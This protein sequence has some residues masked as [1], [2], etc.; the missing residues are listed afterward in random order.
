MPR[1]SFLSASQGASTSSMEVEELL[2]LLKS[3]LV[4]TL[5]V[6]CGCPLPGSQLKGA[7]GSGEGGSGR[8]GRGGTIYLNS[9]FQNVLPC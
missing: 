9:K 2:D 7:G 4:M 1:S 3:K 5:G 6:S 8:E